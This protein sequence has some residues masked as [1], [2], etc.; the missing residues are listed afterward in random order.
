MSVKADKRVTLMVPVDVDEE[1]VEGFYTELHCCLDESPE[2]VLLDCSLLE[3]ATS[4]HIN[5]LWQA[6]NRCEETGT[7]VK[8]T[9]VTY[10]LER[11]LMVLDLYDLFTAERDGV[12]ARAGA[13]K[14]DP[15]A[16]PL[17]ALM[18]EVEPTVD[19][20]AGAME[21]LHK[22]LIGLG[23]GEILA[24]DLE[25]VFYEVTTNIRLHGE[26]RE[27]ETIGFSA[28]TKDGLVHLRFEDPGPHFDPTSRS[29][30]FDPK[31]AMRSRQ[32]NGFGLAM[33][34]RLADGLSYERESDRLNILNLEK[35]IDRNGGNLNDL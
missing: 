13:R 26:L 11:V 29:S 19:G 5:T 16:V 8:L 12:E 33:I 28:V 21:T 22:H 20:I 27:G 32:R 34:K 1:T 30:P 17:A 35:K 24:F 3:R 18:L 31:R 9:S 25:T 15:D 6:R 2:E 7:P 10:G 23:L 14:H 4:T